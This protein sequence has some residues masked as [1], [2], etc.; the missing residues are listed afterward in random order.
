MATEFAS[1]E[2]PD[3]A[4]SPPSP[5][6]VL[7][8]L[9]ITPGINEA[10]SNRMELHAD[11]ALLDYA[12]RAWRVGGEVEVKVGCQQHPAGYWRARG[13]E[14]LDE[15][16]IAPDCMP[17]ECPPGSDCSTCDMAR[18]VLALVPGATVYSS[19]V[20]AAHRTALLAQLNHFLDRAEREL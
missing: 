8:G 15:W 13:E 18:A 6:S 11:S 1:N 20:E 9:V 7:A 5:P 14:L 3:T 17:P 2:Q 19:E 12:V 10:R 4:A 16:N